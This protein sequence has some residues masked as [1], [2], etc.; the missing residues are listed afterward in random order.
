[1]SQLLNILLVEDDAIEVMK[2]TRVLKGM[3][4][5]HKITEASNGE[6]A[7]FAL[8]DREVSTDI[9][10]LDL[11]MPKINGLEFLNIIKNDN[12]LKYIPTVVL[13]TSNNHKD[14]AA[15]YNN[16][17]AGYFVKPLHYAEYEDNIKRMIGYWTKNEFLYQ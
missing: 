1:M 7:L 3:G 13:T 12:D 11:N 4:H 15:C 9:I 2:F 8:K 6:E 14:V 16:G 5:N 10:V 17:V